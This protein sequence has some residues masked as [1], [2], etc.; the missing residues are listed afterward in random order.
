MAQKSFCTLG[1]ELAS[2]AGTD[3]RVEAYCVLELLGRARILPG[4]LNEKRRFA[5]PRL[6]LGPGLSQQKHVFQQGTAISSYSFR[7]KKAFESLKW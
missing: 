3:R 4:R 7:S 5:E 6:L 1:D 2:T